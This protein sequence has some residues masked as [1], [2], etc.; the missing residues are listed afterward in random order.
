MADAAVENPANTVPPHKKQLL[1]SIPNF[2]TLEGFS[3]EGNDDYSTF[4]KLQRQLEYVTL[5]YGRRRVANSRR[6]IH[7]Q[8]EYIKDEQ[9]SLKRELVRA[10]EE[11][12]R[13]QSVPL[14][15][16][17]FMEAIDQK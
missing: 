6:Y 17:Q 13:I 1:S 7:L 3:T 8:E 11:I 16:G 15:I 14:V 2:D 12:K 10:Q 9:R 4:K 5:S